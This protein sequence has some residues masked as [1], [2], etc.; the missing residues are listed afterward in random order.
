MPRPESSFKKKVKSL[1]NIFG[2]D[3][4]VFVL[5]LAFAFF[6]WWSR[7]M[8]SS[9]DTVMQIPV[10]IENVPDDV[11]VLRPSQ[12]HVTLSVS[13]KGIALRKARK[14]G[15]SNSLAIDYRQ[16]ASAKG[17]AVYASSSLRDSLLRYM[18]QTLLIRDIEPDTLSLDYVEQR[19]IHV[20]VV[21]DCY[22][23][24]RDQYYMESVSFQPDSVW[25]FVLSDDTVTRAVYA[26]IDSFTVKSD[27]SSLE[28]GLKSGRN[29]V[30]SENRAV[31]H[32]MAQQYTEKK[33]DVT[34]SGYDFPDGTGLKSFP[35][36]VSVAFWVRLSDYD[37]VTG[38]DFRVVVDYASLSE[39]DGGKARLMLMEK[40]AGVRNVRLLMP[41]V[42]YLL[43]KRTL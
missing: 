29:V 3:F 25:V 8:N 37:R 2:G 42:E 27:T 40:P 1:L 18:P 19:R 6:F 11:R 20:P 13:G 35:S 9:Y 31:M 10:L 4:P 36:V 7:S 32:V 16:F 14:A 30:I 38:D 41:S 21:A 22:F 17:R 24:S 33:V 15:G 43:E 26:D 23:G 28:V 12:E 34:V 5:F 39:N